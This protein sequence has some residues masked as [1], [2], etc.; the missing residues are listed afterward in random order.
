M[1]DTNKPSLDSLIKRIIAD[2]PPDIRQVKSD[3]DM[4]LKQA[5][6]AAF[7]RMD[8]VTREE[9]DIQAALLART[10]ERLEMILKRLDE[11]EANNP[12]DDPAT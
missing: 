3:F 2:L 12:P 10:R 7:N 1:A 9:F 5:L 6:N 8:L 4:Q 11:L